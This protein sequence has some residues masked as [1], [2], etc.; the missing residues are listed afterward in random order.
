MTQDVPGQQKQA[1]LSER[2][3]K[4]TDLYELLEIS[5]L[6]SQSVIQA[7]Y[8]ALARGSHTDLNASAE[9]AQRIRELNAAYAVLSNTQDRACYDLERLRAGRYE[10]VTHA[11]ARTPRAARAGRN[12]G[13]IVRR[14]VSQPRGVD[15]TSTRSTARVV[16][17]VLVVIALTAI[18][19]VLVSAAI[20]GAARS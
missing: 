2:R 11:D 10:R 13:L 7:A 16:V 3:H 19:L 18:V 4:P 15:Q 6:A 12:Y 20:D 8:R 17:A 1:G 5:P 9:A 14:P